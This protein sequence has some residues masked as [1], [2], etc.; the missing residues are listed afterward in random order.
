MRSNFCKSLIVASLLTAVAV[1]QQSAP[2]ASSAS[3]SADIPATKED[4]QRLFDVMH[5]RE[6]MRTTMLLV[7]A[8]QQKMIRETIKQRD[9]AVTDEQLAKMES[10]S[11]DF[12]KDFPLDGMLEDTIPV[13]QKHLTKG[14]VDGMIVFY[15]SGTGQKLLHEQ[16]A[17]AGESMQAM[18][19]RMQKSMSDMIDRIERKAKEEAGKNKPVPVAKPAQRKN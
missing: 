11:Q 18:A 1:G 14:D 19:P 8:Q 7:M 9:P 17:I 12:L 16:P 4:I 2:A 5:L 6:Q 15:S 10:M 13:Y 3:S